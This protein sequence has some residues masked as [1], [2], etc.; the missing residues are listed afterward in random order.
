MN[1]SQLINYIDLH[2]TDPENKQNTAAVVRDVLETMVTELNL[3]SVG[4]GVVFIDA[5]NGDDTNGERGNIAMP[6]KTLSAALSGSVSGDLIILLPGTLSTTTG[7]LIPGREQNY[8]LC[9]GAT[10]IFTPNN[11]EL[12]FDNNIT[13]TCR[14]FGKGTIVMTGTP[15]ANY[16]IEI[17]NSGSV[18]ELGIPVLTLN[19]TISISGSITNRVKVFTINNASANHISVDNLPANGKSIW[20]GVEIHTNF[21]HYNFFDFSGDST[22]EYYFKR[23]IWVDSVGDST[24]TWG[25]PSTSGPSVTLEDCL[26]KLNSDYLM[27]FNIAINIPLTL[28]GKNI[29]NK[30]WRNTAVGY[31][32]NFSGGGELIDYLGGQ[33]INTMLNSPST[34]IG[35]DSDGNLVNTTASIES[36]SVWKKYTIAYSDI[37]AIGSSS[38]QYFLFNLPAGGVIEDIKIKHSQSFVGG[39]IS[40]L[41]VSAGIVGDVAKYSS[42]FSIFQPVASNTFILSAGPYSEDHDNSIGIYLNF[43]AT[44]GLLTALTAGSVDIWFSTSVVK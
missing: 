43:V 42:P 25:L 24:S 9:P 18:L 3:Q 27:D 37:N 21:T 41:T 5:T 44:G 17:Q 29:S 1:K 35:T 13:S 2:I 33:Y 14:V 11:T 40:A 10:L 4:M 22:A 6:F 28:K 31:G 19:N 32:F 23:C 7:L 16:S 12:I 34:L 30:G 20:E 36:I 15:G 39:S 8:Y 26:F 38:T